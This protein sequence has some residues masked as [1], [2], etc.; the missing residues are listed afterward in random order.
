LFG[1]DDGGCHKAAMPDTE[2][3]RRYA[4]TGA[5]DAFAELV[6]RHVDGVYSA[7]L[8]RVGGDTI[9]SRT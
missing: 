5:E 7:A 6:R 9:W 2:L 1:F 8:R 4:D 3:F